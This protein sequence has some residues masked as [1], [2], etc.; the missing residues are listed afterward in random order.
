MRPWPYRTD[1]YHRPAGVAP[2]P[3]HPPPADHVPPP[4]PP[5][6]ATPTGRSGPTP[7]RSR[8]NA[9]ALRYAT[10]TS[11]M[12]EFEVLDS[13]RLQVSSSSEDEDL[14][15]SRPS[16]PRHGRS[17]SN[18]FP[19]LFSNKKKP[20]RHPAGLS[21]SDSSDEAPTMTKPKSRIQTHT[22]RRNMPSSGNRAPS[23]GNKDFATGHCMTCG[24]LVRWPRELHVFRCTICMTINDLQPLPPDE[25]REHPSTDKA[26]ADDGSGVPLGR[27]GRPGQNSK[28]RPQTQFSST[29]A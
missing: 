5:P 26:A 10:N 21:D 4:P 28:T 6:K 29:R 25:R 15:P 24:S 2:P 14:R 19:S 1:S 22:H 7:S 8:S 20:G 17:L 27:P 12:S 16:R 3:P 23:S 9:A 11:R 18:P 13:S